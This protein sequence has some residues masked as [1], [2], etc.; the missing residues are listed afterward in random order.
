MVAGAAHRSSPEASVVLE[1]DD[2]DD[3]DDNRVISILLTACS[4]FSFQKA[5]YWL[6]IKLKEKNSILDKYLN[7]SL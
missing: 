3:D 4:K 1:A 7:P 5:I 6:D 2:D